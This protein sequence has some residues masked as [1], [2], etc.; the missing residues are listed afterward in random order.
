LLLQSRLAVL[1]VQK[2]L[3]RWLPPYGCWLWHCP[4]SLGRLSSGL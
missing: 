2:K 4:L 3:S 1:S